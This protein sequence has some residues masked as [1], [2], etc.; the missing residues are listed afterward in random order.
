MIISI[1]AYPHDTRLAI[2]EL[3]ETVGNYRLLARLDK[4]DFNLAAITYCN[5]KLEAGECYEAYIQHYLKLEVNETPIEFGLAKY[6]EDEEYIS[7]DFELCY[8]NE[9]I[10][11]IEMYNTCLLAEV[12][13]QLNVVW[14]TV[15][16][17]SKSYK[18]NLENPSVTVLY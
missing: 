1:D 13:S 15:N 6:L 10:Y 7:L 11:K 9:P 14:L 18:I 2:F 3:A 16:N 4:H 12:S 8:V 5:Q 17:L